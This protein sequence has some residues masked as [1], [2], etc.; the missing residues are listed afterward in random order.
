[1]EVAQAE[2]QLLVLIRALAS[3]ELALSDEV[4]ETLAVGFQTLFMSN[5]NSRDKNERLVSQS[6]L[7]ALWSF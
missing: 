6:P 5:R 4:V 2:E 7:E 3:L 1:M